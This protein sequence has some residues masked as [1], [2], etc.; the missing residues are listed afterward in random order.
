MRDTEC[1][2]FLQWCLP[3]MSMR[4]V[5]FRRVHKQV[6]KRLQ[7]R[8]RELGLV[9]LKAYRRYLEQHR[10]E[11]H[12]LD[13]LCQITISR[14]YRDRV[15]FGQLSDEVLPELAERALSHA[16]TELRCWSIGCASGEEPYSLALLWH[17]ALAPHYPSLRLEICAS[18]INT[19]LLARAAKACFSAGSIKA[20][21]PDWS[22]QAFAQRGQLYCLKPMWRDAIEFIEQDIRHAQPPGPFDLILCRNLVFTYYDDPLQRR[23][24]DAMAARLRPGAALVVGAHEA[25]P[26]RQSSFQPWDGLRFIYRKA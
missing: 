3:H 19:Q 14:F 23:L 21:P 11:W 8:L 16:R 2:E 26:A 22:A 5:G 25:L 6:C 20:L 7:R 15:V 1:I 24:L 17:F 4:W 13:H 10:V 18:D 12:T 9:D